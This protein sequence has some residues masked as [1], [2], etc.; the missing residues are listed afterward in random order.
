MSLPSTLQGLTIRFVIPPRPTC[1]SL[2]LLSSTPRHVGPATSRVHSAL[3]LAP[4]TPHH[5][6][7]TTWIK[8]QSRVSTIFTVLVLLGVT[9]T[10]YGLYQFYETFHM[11]PPAVRSDLRAGIKAKHNGDLGLSERYLRRALQTALNEPETL[12]DHVHLKLSG[13]AVALGGVLEDAH[14]IRDACDVYRAALGL[15]LDPSS[16]PPLE[17]AAEPDV[18]AAEALEQRPRTLPLLTPEDHLRAASTAHHLAELLAEYKDP[19]WTP[20]EAR[21]QEERWRT[22]AVEEVIRAVRGTAPPSTAAQSSGSA[23]TEKSEEVQTMLSELDLPV[24]IR[25]TDVS[26]PL[27][28]LGRFYLQEGKVEYAVPLYLEALQILIPPVLSPQAQS[29]EPSVIERCR[30]AQIMNNLSEVQLAGRQG[31]TPTARAA[32][33]RWARHALETARRALAE[34]PPIESQSWLPR[35]LGGGDE[36]QEKELEEG[37]ATCL[38]TVIAALFNLGSLLEMSGN[39]TEA[40]GMYTQSWEEARKVNMKEGMR[41]ARAALRRLERDASKSKGDSGK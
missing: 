33:E 27:E 14:R 8:S 5:R 17:P 29:R 18:A 39:I 4:A 11:W 37:L 30:G 16:L 32:A 15:L 7:L 13:I 31:P 6:T 9:S 19:T 26:A 34:A 1:R 25:R 22:C 20:R 24:W 28:A 38:E 2:S 40:Q 23:Q 35:W 41:E 10:A 12:G 3:R 36:E 21:E